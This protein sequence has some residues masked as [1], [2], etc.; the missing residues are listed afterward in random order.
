MIL[1]GITLFNPDMTGLKRNIGAIVGQVDRLICVDN[2]TEEIDLI[3]H[4]IKGIYPEVIFI[5]NG[6][7][8][9][10]AKALNQMFIYAEK[11]GFKWVLTLDQDSVC[12]CNII[13][14]YRKYLSVPKVG[15]LCPIIDDRNYANND[16][17]E[18]E[19]IYVEKC[20]TSASLTSVEAWKTV[21]GFFNELFIDF[22]DHDFSAKLIE[23]NYLIVRVNAVRLEHEIGHG[24]T[25]NFLGKKITVLNHSAFRKFYMTRNWI[26]YMKAHKSVINYTEERIKF[27]FFFLKTILYEEEKIKKLKEMLRGVREAKVFCLTFLKKE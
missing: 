18:G 25:V 27:I 26:Y 19:I 4:E 21:D 12:P 22:V 1:A 2:G 20:I 7:N 23:N 24:R 11:E 8:L 5:K 15:S 6:K 10:I 16:I 9:G 13:S 17:I 3:E 14:E